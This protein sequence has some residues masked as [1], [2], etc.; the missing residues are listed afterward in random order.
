M[1]YSIIVW[2]R[3][4]KIINVHGKTYLSKFSERVMG[5]EQTIIVK[6]G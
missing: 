5:G 2:S 1:T 3:H 4:G 6:A